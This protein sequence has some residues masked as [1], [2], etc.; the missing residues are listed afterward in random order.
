[1]NKARATFNVSASA[2]FKRVA[3]DASRAESAPS[4]SRRFVALSLALAAASTASAPGANAQKFKEV[5]DPTEDGAECR[6]NILAQDGIDVG[7][8]EVGGSRSFKAANPTGAK[9]S[10]TTYQSDTLEFVGEVEALLA[11]DVYDGSREK[12]VAAFQKKSNNWSGNS[13]M[14]SGRAFYN[15]LNQLAGHYSFNGLAPI[16]KSRLDVVETNIAKTKE[17]IAAGR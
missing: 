3:E 7:A 13:K 5:C 11:M 2:L 17:L 16:P 9:T 8:Y 1:M 6:A 10:F 15:A 12:A 4:T 14:A